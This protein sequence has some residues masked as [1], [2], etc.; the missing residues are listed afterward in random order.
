MKKNETAIK[1]RKKATEILSVYRKQKGMTQEELA[2]I[3]GTTKSGIS[4]VESGEQNI[5][6]DLYYS[7]A[8]ALG[9]QPEVLME[10]IAEYGVEPYRY[11]LRI[12]DDELLTFTLKRDIGLIASIEE[13]NE[14][15]RDLF[16]LDLELT[17]DGVIRW[18]GHRAIPKNRAFVG[19]ILTS[20]GLD[21]N[22]LKGL[23][24]IGKG[25]SVNDSYWIV[26]KGFPGKFDDYN[27]YEND[28]SNILSLVAYT[29][30][31]KKIR[32][33]DSSP[34]LTT[35][36]MLRKA[37]RFKGE[38]GIWLYK[39]GT[40]DFA[41]AGNEPYSEFYACQVAERMGL[42]AIHY[43]L[44]NWKGILASK[45]KLF[46]DKDLS[47]VPVGRIVR[48]GGIK[49]CLDYY[50]SLGEV[51]YDQL[52]SM[53]VFDTVVI[54]ED[55]HFGNFGLLRYNRTGKIVAPAPIFDN[56]NSLLC[57]AMKSDFDDIDS[58]IEKRSNPYNISFYDLAKMIMGPT[59]K[60]QLK[61][62]IGF[63]FTESDLCNLPSWRLKALEE[64]IQKRV[65]I[66][67]S[68]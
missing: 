58:Y 62:L 64:I 9:K 20:L 1:N 8:D 42:N 28:F 11:S 47:Y 40:E 35:G 17:G 13:V 51:F 55:R 59:Q 16:P 2:D 21:V 23:I 27:L 26:P 31:E 50:R 57:Y 34:E 22:D 24:D 15:K 44:E 6:L 32:D 41:N 68:M 30:V 56:G 53:L 37:W 52:C 25:L 10:E 54:N 33:L 39:G 14:E 63:K 45:C 46:T 4:R 38:K 65:T 3:V 12:Y 29:G 48:T 60:K 7:I 49:A 18:L 67:L 19:E 43:E 66:L 5:S 36:G 61:K